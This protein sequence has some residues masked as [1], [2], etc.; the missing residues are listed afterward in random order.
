MTSIAPRFDKG[1][2]STEIDEDL[3]EALAAQAAQHSGTVNLP[4]DGSNE[5]LLEPRDDEQLPPPELPSEYLATDRQSLTETD[6][7]SAHL[8]EHWGF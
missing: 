8:N 2:G 7:Y 1:E 5:D 3:L 4:F 6:A